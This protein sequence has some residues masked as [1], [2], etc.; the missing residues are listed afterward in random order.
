[1]ED[2]AEWP[3]PEVAHQHHALGLNECAPDGVDKSEEEE[4][5][6]EEGE[7]REREDSA[8]AADTIDLTAAHDG[9][10]APLLPGAFAAA[11]ETRAAFG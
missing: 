4:E 8:G 5:E 6:C 1:M 9:P 11:R 7:E 10:S 3:P 2:R